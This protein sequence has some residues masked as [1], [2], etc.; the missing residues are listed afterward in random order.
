MADGT[1]ALK[2]RHRKAAPAFRTLIV[3]L[4]F[5][6]AIA[7]ITT[8]RTPQLLERARKI[9]KAAPADRRIILS[10]HS[11]LLFRYTLR[12]HGSSGDDSEE[13][14]YLQ[15]VSAGTV[16]L[17]PALTQ[18][19]NRCWKPFNF[20]VT[21]SPDGKQLLFWQDMAAFTGGGIISVDGLHHANISYRGGTSR[22]AAWSEDSRHVFL[23]PSR[24]GRLSNGTWIYDIFSAEPSKPPKNQRRIHLGQL[25][26]RFRQIG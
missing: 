9:G 1:N 15:D 16:T 7:A 25:Q 23:F 26:R 13:D 22:G 19:Y 12:P 3:L 8:P 17:Q 5:G 11:L 2:P 24:T 10:D 18:W 21:V 6:A 14:L 4:V 20:E